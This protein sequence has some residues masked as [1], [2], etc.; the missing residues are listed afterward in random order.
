[1]TFDVC[2]K[3]TTS[4][5][6]IHSSFPLYSLNVVYHLKFLLPLKYILY[7]KQQFLKRINNVLLENKR[8]D[9]NNKA[10]SYL[11]VMKLVI[12]R[13]ILSVQYSQNPIKIEVIGRTLSPNHTHSIRAITLQLDHHASRLSSPLPQS[14]Q[15]EN[16]FHGY[17]SE[18]D[19]AHHLHPITP[20]PHKCYG[21]PPVVFLCLRVIRR[22]PDIS[23]GLP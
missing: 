17:F 11:L 1:M 16:K 23:T 13:S 6:S 18:R 8:F 5:S 2:L 20:L 14:S 19:T 21:W 12:L 4:H 9:K 15:T 22:Y 10:G 3:V 7:P